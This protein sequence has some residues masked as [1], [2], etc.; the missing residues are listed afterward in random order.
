M[1]TF[2]LMMKSIVITMT[3]FIQYFEWSKKYDISNVSEQYGWKMDVIYLW[4]KK[5]C[6]GKSCRWE[7]NDFISRF[8]RISECFS[9]FIQRKLK[10]FFIIPPI[11]H[12]HIY[13]F[14]IFLNINFVNI[15][16][17]SFYFSFVIKI[18]S[19]H[20]CMTV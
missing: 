14:Y 4:K 2:Y 15:D 20:S 16:N 3:V 5:W 13:I 9:K 1:N 8:W 6:V 11:Y 12:M 17:R 18:F 7:S 10:C 19:N